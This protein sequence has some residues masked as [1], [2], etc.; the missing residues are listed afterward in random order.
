MAHGTVA[1]GYRSVQEGL[2]EG[3][4]VVAPKTKSGQVLPSQ[5]ETAGGAVGGMAGET[6]SDSCRRMDD[7]SLLRRLMTLRAKPHAQSGQLESGGALPG[8][9]PRQAA[10]ARSAIPFDDRA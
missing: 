1:G 6:V 5:Q 9:F 3:A 7:L 10:V 2:E 8:V 4:V